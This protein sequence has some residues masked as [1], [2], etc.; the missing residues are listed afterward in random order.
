MGKLCTWEDPVD[1]IISGV[2]YLSVKEVTKDTGE[3]G[4]GSNHKW[5]LNT[6]LRHLN[7]IL[8]KM[9]PTK[10][11]LFFVAFILFLNQNNDMTE[12]ML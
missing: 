5:Y 2:C 11:L 3:G 10:C 6:V 4:L 7:F 8:K 1:V 9:A 12:D